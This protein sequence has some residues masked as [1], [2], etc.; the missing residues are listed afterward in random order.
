M[1][2]EKKDSILFKEWFDNLPF[3][4]RAGTKQII[5]DA[6]GIAPT[7]I[8]NWL[9]GRSNIPYLTKIKLNEIAGETVFSVEPPKVASLKK[10]TVES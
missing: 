5:I 1:K 9:Y 2:K 10:E 3:R 8:D 4:Q 7:T 6:C